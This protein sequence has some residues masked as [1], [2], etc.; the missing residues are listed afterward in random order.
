MRIIDEIV[1]FLEKVVADE[2]FEFSSKRRVL[3]RDESIS[4]IYIL[5]DGLLEVEITAEEQIKIKNVHSGNISIMGHHHFF[6]FM[7]DFYNMMSVKL[8]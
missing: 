2:T 3:N 4:T 5:V 6:N 7:D 8:S 1:E